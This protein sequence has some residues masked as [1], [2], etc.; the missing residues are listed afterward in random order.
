MA[1]PYREYDWH[2]LGLGGRETR[3]GVLGGD[4]IRVPF[5]R[6]TLTV[7]TKRL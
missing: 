2:D 6:N 5:R 4:S 3:D 7:F 1:F